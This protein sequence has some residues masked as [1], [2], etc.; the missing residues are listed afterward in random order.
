[1]TARGELEKCGGPGG[2]VNTLVSTKRFEAAAKR[3]QTPGFADIES[4]RKLD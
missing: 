2:D 1:M 3:M 4:K